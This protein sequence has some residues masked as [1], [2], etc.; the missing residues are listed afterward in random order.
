LINFGIR[1]VRIP[2]KNVGF[3]ISIKEYLGKNFKIFG[4]DTFFS[5]LNSKTIR[6]QIN[7]SLSMDNC[8]N[9]KISFK[10]SLLLLDAE[11][12]QKSCCWCW[13]FKRGLLIQKNIF[14]DNICGQ[15]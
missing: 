7:L 13:N 2:P 5:N 1:S 6:K 15:N 4:E 8:S 14:A 11:D 9:F 3:C 10:S 12:E